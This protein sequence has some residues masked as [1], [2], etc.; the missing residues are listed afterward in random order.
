MDLLNELIELELSVLDAIA[1]WVLIVVLLIVTKF[2]LRGVNDAAAGLAFKFFAGFRRD[3][4]VL[5]DNKPAR[6]RLIDFFSTEFDYIR[7][8]RR[9]GTKRPRLKVFNSELRRYKICKL[10]DYDQESTDK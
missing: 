1:P 8:E 5:V 3:M 9:L 6:I 7:P 4:V 2:I 10:I